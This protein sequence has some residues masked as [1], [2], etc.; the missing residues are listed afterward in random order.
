MTDR[1]RASGRLLLVGAL[2]LMFA[3][4]AGCLFYRPTPPWVSPPRA[5]TAA[6]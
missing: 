5:V 6:P 1:N 2:A 4:L 3:V